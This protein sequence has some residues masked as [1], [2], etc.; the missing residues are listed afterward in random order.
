MTTT[1]APVRLQDEPAPT[2]TRSLKSLLS[3]PIVYVIAL[4][5]IGSTIAPVIYSALGGFRST[6]Q[7]AE[8]PVALPKPW[9]FDNYKNTLT[10]EVFWRQ[11]YNSSVVALITT[12]LVVVLGLMAAFALSR[13]E[14]RGREFIYTIFTLGLLFPLTVGVLPLFLLIRQMDL[15]DNPMGVALPQ[16]AFALPMT[17]VILRPFLRALPKEIE[18]AAVI[19]GCSKIGFFWRIVIPLSG[20]GVV[21]TGVLAFVGSWNAYLLPLL[22]LTEPDSYTLPLGVATYSTQYTQDT[23]AVLAFTSLAMLPALTFFLLA[24]RRIVGGLTGAVKG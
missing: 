20:P 19:D 2:A 18:E 12:V 11:V 13:Y 1:T 3:E 8:K 10:S 5:V 6:G 9:I 15:A 14:F 24:Q 4:G 23:A 7:I 16:A 22:L 21:T 17:I